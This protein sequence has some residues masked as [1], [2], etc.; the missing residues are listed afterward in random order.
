MQPVH[1]IFLLGLA[2]T[3]LLGFLGLI[4][5]ITIPIRKIWGNKKFMIIW[6]TILFL[7]LFDHYFL[8]LPQGYRLLFLMWGLSFSM[9]EFKNGKSAEDI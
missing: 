6:G 5:L 9:L 2:E 1:N 4:I 7:G 8:T 3:G